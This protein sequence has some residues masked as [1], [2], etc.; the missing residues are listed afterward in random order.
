MDALSIPE[1]R[2]GR[3]RRGLVERSLSAAPEKFARELEN[4]R[5]MHA[6]QHAW[7]A[8]PA[9]FAIGTVEIMLARFG[10]VMLKTHRHFHRSHGRT[11]C[12]QDCAARD[13]CAW[14]ALLLDRVGVPKTAPRWLL[15]REA[16]TKFSGAELP[17]HADLQRVIR[18][19][20]A[21]LRALFAQS[22]LPAARAVRRF[23][24]SRGAVCTWIAYGLAPAF[25]H[26]AEMPE[27]Y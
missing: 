7:P 12:E 6:R 27:P 24:A 17:D 21:Q 15:I 4:L 10:S 22:T 3:R 25:D 26:P 18:R 9:V 2:R 19:D 5:S 1:V 20:L 8:T 13:L 16:V 14:L 11:L 23:V